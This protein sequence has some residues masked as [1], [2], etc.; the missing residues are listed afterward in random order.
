MGEQVGGSF[1]EIAARRQVE[2]QGGT[3]GIFGRQRTEGQQRLARLYVLSVQP[4]PR[5]RRIVGGELSGR[6]RRLVVV[7]C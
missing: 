5:A 6:H 2:H 4:Q 1:D 3:V 7:G